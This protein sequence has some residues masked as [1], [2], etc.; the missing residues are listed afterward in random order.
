M[1]S[2][3]GSLT[4]TKHLSVISP[5]FVCAINGTVIILKTF[6]FLNLKAAFEHTVRLLFLFSQNVTGK[7]GWDVSKTISTAA[8]LV[9]LC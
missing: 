8:A 3:P 4:E 5:P 7:G 6:F 9:F 2:N 1:V